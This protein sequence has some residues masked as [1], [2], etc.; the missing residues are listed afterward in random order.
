MRASPQT[1]D[2]RYARDLIINNNNIINFT[3]LSLLAR[4]RAPQIQ[5]SF[6]TLE[7]QNLKTL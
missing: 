4:I 3:N 2:P 6:K 5:L 1:P 7:P